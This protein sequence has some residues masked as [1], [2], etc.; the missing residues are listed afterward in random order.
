MRVPTSDRGAPAPEVPA[1]GD[2]GFEWALARLKA[3]ERIA[4][5]GWN[6]RGMYVFIEEATGPG[7]APAIMMMTAQGYLVPWLASQTDIL[8]SDWTVV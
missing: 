3:G 4:R 1:E 5:T 7:R 8:S 6:G 2:M